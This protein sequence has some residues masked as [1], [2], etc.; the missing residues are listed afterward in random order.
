MKS[1][2][3]YK[4]EIC[5]KEFLLRGFGTHIKSHNMTKEEYWSKYKYPYELEG[6]YGDDYVLCPICN[7][8]KPYDTL[9]QHLRMKHN[10]SIEDFLL[11]YPGYKTFTEH[12]HKIQSD[13]CRKGLEKSWSSIEYRQKKIEYLRAN[14]H[15][16][17]MTPEQ[18]EHQKRVASER[19]KKDWQ[20]PDYQQKMSEKMSNQHKNQ[21]LQKAILNGQRK[22]WE[23][24]IS[25][26]NKTFKIKSSYEELVA[27]LLDSL[28][29]SYDYEKVFKYFDSKRKKYR[30]YYADFYLIDYDV[31][32][33]VKASWAIED[34]TVLDKMKGVLQTGTKFKFITEQEL[35][36][37]VSIEQL[38]KLIQSD[39]K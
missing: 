39:K 5:G 34:Q 22:H 1:S 25:W 16:K 7:D 8:N 33:E 28:K 29:I 2:K 19:L 31:V 37:L 13:R 30:N 23:E 12:Y 36:Q 10:M 6:K 3:K 38:E 17:Q 18:R 26:E 24:H 14:P 21:N 32:L 15:L 35:G 20:R 9:K 27:N 4:C 11:S